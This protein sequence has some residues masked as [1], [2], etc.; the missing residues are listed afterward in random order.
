MS[1]LRL[2]CSFCGREKDPT[3]YFV[4]GPFT[5][6]APALICRACARHIDQEIGRHMFE[7]SIAAGCKGTREPGGVLTPVFKE[8]Q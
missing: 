8:E 1:D 3:E 4:A 7:D 6:S 5:N 2:A